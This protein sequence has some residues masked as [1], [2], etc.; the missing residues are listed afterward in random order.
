MIL[1]FRKTYFFVS[2]WLR[3]ESINFLRAQVKS[4][5]S[6]K[7]LHHFFSNYWKTDVNRPIMNKVMQN[8]MAIIFVSEQTENDIPGRFKKLDRFSGKVTK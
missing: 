8:T 3:S 2:D 4:L 5:P 6:L 7:D 1:S